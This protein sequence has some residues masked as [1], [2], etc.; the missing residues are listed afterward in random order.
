MHKGRRDQTVLGC[1]QKQISACLLSFKK[2][3][4]MTIVIRWSRAPQPHINCPK[5]GSGWY[6]SRWTHKEYANQHL[7]V[8]CSHLSSLSVKDYTHKLLT[9]M[10][11]LWADPVLNIVAVG[12]FE[13]LLTEEQQT[14]GIFN[15]YSITRTEIQP[16]VS[17]YDHV[18]KTVA[19]VKECNW[20]ERNELTFAD[21]RMM[22][23][24]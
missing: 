24:Y 3:E 7:T 13:A 16:G 23:K 4:Y 1:P 12:S 2:M 19:M 6:V 5:I 11:K 8:I 20:T 15:S 17:F 14:C 21:N 9:T 10:K 22:F 18:M